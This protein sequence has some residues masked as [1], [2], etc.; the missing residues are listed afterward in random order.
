[1]RRVV[2][3]FCINPLAVQEQDPS[4]SVTLG[5]GRGGR[6]AEPPRT[7]HRVVAYRDLVI[8]GSRSVR[9]VRAR[10]GREV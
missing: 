2:R 3:S 9:V 7:A 10:K 4:P 1:M 8:F 5:V 6:I